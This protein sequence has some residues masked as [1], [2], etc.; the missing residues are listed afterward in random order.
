VPLDCSPASCNVCP[1]A[2]PCC[3]SFLAADALRCSGAVY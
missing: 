2:E 3:N 1:S